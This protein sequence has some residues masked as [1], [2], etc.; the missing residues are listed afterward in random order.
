MRKLLTF[1]IGLVFT[2]GF[3]QAQI[4]TFPY[5]EDFDSWTTCPATNACPTPCTL[6][7]ASGWSNDPATATIRDWVIDNGGTPSGSTGPS[8]DHTTGTFTGNYLFVETS[9]ACNND[10][11]NLNTPWFDFSNVPSP[12]VRWWYHMFG[13]SMGTM[14]LDVDTSGNTPWIRD[15]IPPFTDNQDIWQLQ[16][17]LLCQ[18]GGLDSVRFRIRGTTGTSFFSDMAVD[19]FE[20]LGNPL[21]DAGIAAVQSPT[22]PTCTFGSNPLQVVLQNF[23]CSPIDSA[24]IGWSLNGVTQTPINYRPTTPVAPGG[25]A[26]V[27]LGTFSFSN[28][29]SIKVWTSLPNGIVDNS[30]LNDTT[31]LLL[32]GGLSGTYTINSATATGGTNFQSFSDAVTA[33]NTFGV[34]GPTVFNVTAGS[35]PYIEQVVLGT[36]TGA[37]AL[38]TITFNGG[39]T[40]EEIYTTTAPASQ[41][42]V[43]ELNGASFVTLRNLKISNSSPTYGLGVLLTNQSDFNTIDS[44]VI[45]VD[46]ALATTSTFRIPIVVGVPTSIFT[47]STSGEFNTITN[48]YTLGGYTSL[49]M[50]YQSTTVKSRGNVITGN[51]FEDAS[52]YGFR[53]YAMDTL[54]VSQNTVTMQNNRTGGFGYGMD[55]QYCDNFTVEENVITGFPQYGMYFLAG[56]YQAN[57]SN[58]D[59]SRVV[60]NMISKGAAGTGS[61]FQYG[62]WLTT[63]CRDMDIWHNSVSI[64]APNASSCR[65]FYTSSTT[66]VR[67]DV[68]NNSFAVFNQGDALYLSSAAV[69]DTLDFNNYYNFDT[70]QVI[71]IAGGLGLG[72]YKSGA[73]NAN[74]DYGDPGYVDNELDLHTKSPQLND[75]GDNSVGITIDIDGD[76]RPFGSALIVD[77]GADE[78]EPPR[79]DAGVTAL[80]TPVLPICVGSQT[81]CVEFTNFGLDTIDTI[82]V[83]WSVNGV[84]QTTATL[85]NLSL[86]TGGTDTVCLGS[87]TF[88]AATNY[89]F[90]FYTDDPNNS[91]D[92]DN[93]NDTLSLL[94]LQTGLPGGTYTID[95]AVATGGTNYQSFEDAADALNRFG[96]CG[97]VVFNVVANSGPYQNMMILENVQGTSATNTITFDGGATKERIFVNTSQTSTGERAVIKVINTDY[98]SF[99]NLSV[100]NWSTITPTTTFNTYGYGFH[101]LDGSDFNVV[102]SCFIEVDTGK[103]ATSANF[104]GIV[105]AGT[106]F[107]TS[108]ATTA[109][110]LTITNNVIDGGYYGVSI[111]YTAFNVLANGNRIENNEIRDSYVYGIYSYAQNGIQINGNRINLRLIPGITST[112]G[113]GIYQGYNDDFKVIGNFISDPKLY[114]IFCFAANQ[115]VPPGTRSQYIN[116]MIFGSWTNGTPYG[117]YFSSNVD[118]VDVFHNSIAMTS[119]N[120]RSLYSF[121]TTTSGLDIRNNVF[122]NFNSGLFACDIRQTS[123]VTTFDYNC[124]YNAGD[125]TDLIYFGQPYGS[126]TYQGAGTAN[127]NSVD[128][129][130][131]YIDPLTDLHV[132]GGLLINERGQNSVGIS[133][134][135]DGD[136]R[137]SVGALIV[138]MG[139]DEFEPVRLDA[140]LLGFRTPQTGCGL[141]D[142]T[143]VT[144]SILNNGIDTI[145]NVGVSYRLGGVVI[146]DT[147]RQ[148]I[149]PGVVFNYVMSQTANL[150]AAGTYTFDAWVG[151]PGDTLQFNDST[152]NYDV[153]NR[154][155]TITTYPYDQDFEDTAAFSPNNGFTVADRGGAAITFGAGWENDQNDQP[156]A[157]WQA[158]SANTPNFA[159]GPN[160][161]HTTGGGTYLYVDDQRE[162]TVNLLTPCFD[163]TNLNAPQFS[164]WYSTFNRFTFFTD[165]ELHIDLFV[166]GAYILDII[167]PILSESDTTWRFQN[168]DLRAYKGQIVNLRFRYEGSNGSGTSHDLAIDDINIFDLPPDD[169]GAV[170]LI[171]PTSGLCGDSMMNVR[172][173]VENFGFEAQDSFG[174]FVRIDGSLSTTLSTVY[175][176]TLLPDT[177]DIVDMGTINTY[178]GGSYVFT[179]YTVMPSDADSTNDTVFVG[180]IQVQGIPAAPTATGALTCQPDSLKLFVDQDTTTVFYW[181]DSIGGQPIFIGD[182]LST[183]LITSTQ[184]YFVQSNAFLGDTLT[185]TFAAGNGQD[186]N[187][188]DI[189][190]V[191]GIVQVD[192]FDVHING[193]GSNTVE[194]YYVT[195]GGSYVGNE[196]NAAAWTLLG[197]ATVTGAGTGNPTR[198]P[199][200]GLTISPGQTFGLYVTSTTG[201]FA[202]TNGGAP[203]TT[204]A[205]NDISLDLGVG[206]SYP[207]GLTFSPRIWNGIVHYSR[208]GCPSP[209]TT[210]NAVVSAT[211]PLSLGPDVT[212]CGAVPLTATPGPY[213]YAWN[214]GDTT[215]AITAT[216]TGTY[217]VVVTDPAGCTNTD[218]IN[219]FTN[220]KPP[221]SL[222][223]D[224]T[225]CG[226]VLLDAGNPGFTTS[227]S[228]GPQTQT[229]LITQSGSYSVI[230]Q[231]PVTGC[232]NTDT[233]N[234][235]INPQPPVD[236][237]PDRT[238]CDEEVLTLNNPNDA[239]IWS[240]GDTTQSI[241][242]NTSGAVFVDVTNSF[243]CVG[244]D[245]VLLTVTPSPTVDL[246]LDTTECD[247][248]VIDAGN[249]GATYA[250]SDGNTQQTNIVSTSGTYSVKVTDNNGC[251]GFDTVN[252]NII[253]APTAFGYIVNQPGTYVTFG[254]SSKGGN[255]TYDWD[256][257]DGNSSTL[258]NPTHNYGQSGA[259]TVTLTVDNKCGTSQII[260]EVISFVG[261]E[262]EILA[263]S[264]SLYPNPTNGIFNISV[265]GLNEDVEVSVSDAR[266]RVVHESLIE[267]TNQ[268]QATQVDLSTVAEGVYLVKFQVDN[269][270]SVRKLIVR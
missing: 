190:A 84:A 75:K 102:D 222:G 41:R 66:I 267:A 195:G 128:G 83:K 236:L 189:T 162:G 215:Q 257:G 51:T 119:G 21:V 90:L 230:V 42:A 73:A 170:A 111:T 169:I 216:T 224:T 105:A 245:T 68:R 207:F 38:N 120:A 141:D 196:T 168:I 138:D 218:T 89:D 251:E 2:M 174:V 226:S 158:R 99:K 114:G 171:E 160:G 131:G 91:I 80:V 40:K 246:G 167:P 260:F 118:D 134:D 200:G 254:D 175:R 143:D 11:A 18:F 152:F 54:V 269:R 135:I 63:F 31:R 137:P 14:H 26:Q 203:I 96:I 187:M 248:Y 88:A 250:W 104:A 113:Y 59:R 151:L 110:N 36:I 221:L 81:I 9:G 130:P 184:T 44:C 139:A 85:T 62:L 259:F 33:L 98:V 124:F 8:V 197:S 132:L 72:S 149:P 142:S 157:D 77:M 213:S 220:P 194:V 125:T 64:N 65:G 19:D 237:G 185:T 181:Y 106:G 202:Y 58:G 198:V 255:L 204:I 242:V 67:L 172:V 183:G 209:F 231:N 27:T 49:S 29:D 22:V 211:P 256:F 180:T 217:S 101:F 208:P 253:T 48:N 107:A 79:T 176:D 76:T 25:F 235:T 239:V 121:S 225:S 28:G 199:V 20:V 52:T 212:T 191:S 1:V 205:N 270:I 87:F 123:Q 173:Q 133:T 247:V 70:A 146:T 223:A 182:T 193:T 109:E 12:S 129:D 238:A 24:I 69:V 34:C 16:A 100:S 161:D 252:V 188:F 156:A 268:T 258:P 179:A 147:I 214:T 166:N 227:W 7:V 55:F 46:S 93:A 23:A 39:S 228:N 265:D 240:N 232:D 94:Q 97:P 249:P 10:T 53:L 3:T 103:T 86:P 140:A 32:S 56:N 43:I 92:E 122:A 159:T 78:F 74:S 13:T 148:A 178:A 233:I 210:V 241:T 37:S 117:M 126:A 144:L 266:G 153:T 30:N 262:D 15:V 201:G 145:R 261:I 127:S 116:N 17:V 243:G 35:G 6:P 263:N 71:W 186:G 108:Q 219:V 82:D 50:R 57:S 61:N 192:S 165:N 136:A 4:S 177:S 163:F 206:K 264:I 60:N 155:F 115:T 229:N 5:Q 244:T 154:S 47:N 150:L 112:F 234:V 45:V 95:S 164:F